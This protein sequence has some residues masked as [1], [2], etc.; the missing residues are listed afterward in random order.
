MRPAPSI[1]FEWE[2]GLGWPVVLPDSGLIPKP[3]WLKNLLVA[4]SDYRKPAVVGRTH[5]ETRT[6]YE[7]AEALF[8]AFTN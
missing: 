3:G 4:F 8:W 6:L 5:M 1:I 2:T 7:R